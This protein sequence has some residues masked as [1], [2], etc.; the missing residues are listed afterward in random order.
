MSQNR[1]WDFFDSHCRMGRWSFW[2]WFYIYISIHFWWR[3]A[4][5]TIFTY[6]LPV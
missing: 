2:S 5:K 1:R 6:S 3:Y 4:R